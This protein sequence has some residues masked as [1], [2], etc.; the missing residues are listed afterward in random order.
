MKRLSNITLVVC[1]KNRPDF[2]KRLIK[3]INLQNVLPKYFV[4]I[5]DIKS[6]PPLPSSIINSVNSRI[7]T[8]HYKVKYCSISQSRN[9]A[10]TKCNSPIFISVDDDIVLP[11]KYISTIEKL[12]QL[13][14]NKIGFVC[15]I[16]AFSKDPLSLTGQ[17]IMN[18]RCLDGEALMYSH[19]A[20]YSLNW[21][22]FKNIGLN[23]DNGLDTGEDVDFFIR[24]KKNGYPI[25]F[26]TKTYVFHDFNSHKNGILRYVSYG[27]CRIKISLKHPLQFNYLWCLP[28]RKLDFIFFL[29]LFIKNIIRLTYQDY[30]SIHLPIWLLPFMISAKAALLLGMILSKEG[31]EIIKNN[32]KK[33]FPF[34]YH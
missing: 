4:I 11:Q 16:K 22:V 33:S 18:G 27:K 8:K 28:Q 14:P 10:F 30:E 1:T 24:L 32:F 23:F 17:Y 5:D 29:P 15:K 13:F 19:T 12:H 25:F 34:F 20:A 2:I 9:F 31:K 26:T 6:S 21:S 3:S 7:K